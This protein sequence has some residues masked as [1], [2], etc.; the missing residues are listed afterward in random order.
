MK[1][2]LPAIRAYSGTDVY[3]TRL[4]DGL[5]RRGIEVEITWFPK[6]FEMAAS[7]LKAVEPPK[8]TDLVLANSWN[9]FAFKRAHI[10][11]VIVEHL[12]VFDEAYRPFKTFAQHIYHETLVRRRE[13]ASFAK[14]DAVVAVSASTAASMERGSKLGHIHVIHNWI[15]VDVFQPR[16]EHTPLDDGQPFRLLFVGNPSKRKGA[17]MLG[18]IMSA[19]GPKFELRYT[20][21]LKNRQVWTAANMRPLG[22]LSQPEVIRAYHECDALL[23]PSRLE[24]FAYAALEAMACGVPVVASDASSLPEAIEDGVSGSL[25]E[26]GN[27]SAFVGACRRLAADQN[28]LQDMGRAARERVVRF[29]SEEASIVK[30]V[31]L[32]DSLLGSVK[33]R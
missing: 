11:L 2:W 20:S 24:G 30:Y 13:E 6:R 19:L 12:Y 9:G 7:M 31:C 5:R 4:A 33:S 32:F 23:F 14:A 16:L 22:S 26:S 27:V 21:G 17:D 28:L 3:T 25:C 29:F 18:P 10:P 15:D 1:I 8:G